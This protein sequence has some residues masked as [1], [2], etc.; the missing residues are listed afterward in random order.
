MKS[1]KERQIIKKLV[2]QQ[3]FLDKQR[4][5]LF[6]KTGT[7]LTSYS[8]PEY[9]VDF[10]DIACDILGFPADTAIMQMVGDLPENIPVDKL[11]SRMF[12]PHIYDIEKDPIDEWLVERATNALY[13]KLHNDMLRFPEL[14]VDKQ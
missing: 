9:A 4:R 10:I 5:E 12:L 14:F 8:D 2:E 13:E 6:N 3:L 1:D 7:S 11:Y